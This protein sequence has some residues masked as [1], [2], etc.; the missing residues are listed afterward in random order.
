MIQGQARF[1]ANSAT[2][3]PATVLENLLV[4]INAHK[5]D[6]QAHEYRCSFHPG[7]FKYCIH[8]KMCEVNYGPT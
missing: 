5:K 2:V 7:G 6:P 4:F 3:F 1:I 8:R